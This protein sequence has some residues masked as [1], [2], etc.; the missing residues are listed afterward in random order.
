[1]RQLKHFYSAVFC[2][3]ALFLMLVSCS[4]NEPKSILKEQVREDYN[5]VFHILDAESSEE[6]ELYSINELAEYVKE[7]LGN[8]F[9]NLRHIENFQVD[10]IYSIDILPYAERFFVNVYPEADIQE[11]YGNSF[12]VPDKFL[13][14]FE[15]PD[16][17]YVITYADKR[18]QSPILLANASKRWN[19]NLL[20]NIDRRTYKLILSMI[21]PPSDHGAGLLDDPYLNHPDG[22]IYRGLFDEFGCYKNPYADLMK[23][24]MNITTAFRRQWACGGTYRGETD[25][26]YSY[27][28]FIGWNQQFAE[29]QYIL[30]NNVHYDKSGTI[31]LAALK[32]LTIKEFAGYYKG[33]PYDLSAAALP[34]RRKDEELFYEL[35][36]NIITNSGNCYQQMRYTDSLFVE[37]GYVVES[38]YGNE[39]SYLHLWEVIANQD[40]VI[41]QIGGKWYNLY[42]IRRTNL[43]L[44]YTYLFFLDFNDGGTTDVWSELPYCPWG[45]PFL[46]K[47]R[48]IK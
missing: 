35:S 48:V 43:R 20:D 25:S 18:F 45:N 36:F 41:Y 37:L 15:S 14:V 30:Y 29:D 3:M 40:A 39:D 21:N 26:V 23:L 38:M 8:D 28:S 17:G 22:S 2:C 7:V 31:P 46:G 42:K 16:L 34:S 4:T 33:V 24:Y 27:E 12:V 6:I 11:W 9:P 5:T 1:M 19:P 32:A 47:I 10:T 13:Y 44:A